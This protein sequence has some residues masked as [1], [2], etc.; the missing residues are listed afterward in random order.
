M[1]FYLAGR[2]AGLAACHF[3]GN[4][5]CHSPT[6]LLVSFSARVRGVKFFGLRGGDGWFWECAEVER[7]PGNSYDANCVEV[8]VRGRRL[9]HLAK[10]AAEFVLP[11]L[12]AGFVIKAGVLSSIESVFGMPIARI[13]CILFPHVHAH[14]VE[15]HLVRMWR[16]GGIPNGYQQLAV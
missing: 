2:P 9:G 15:S 3:R 1:T 7:D 16:E 12:A 10:E 14:I 8:L 5:A 4:M 13:A 11:L 6:V